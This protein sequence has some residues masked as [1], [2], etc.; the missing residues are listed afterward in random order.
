MQTHTHTERKQPSPRPAAASGIQVAV[1]EV[2]HGDISA[3][4]TLSILGAEESDALRAE[5]LRTQWMRAIRGEAEQ[6]IFGAMMILLTQHLKTVSTRGHGGKF[7]EKGGGVE[8]WLKENA[9]EIKRPTAYRWMKAAQGLLQKT[10]IAGA[11][12]LQSLLGTAEADLP[13][14]Q[15][16]QQMELFSTMGKHSQG[17]LIELAPGHRLGGSRHSQCPKC[18]TNLR[19]SSVAICPKC[20][21]STGQEAEKS[22]TAEEALAV[23]QDETRRAIRDLLESGIAKGGWKLLEDASVRAL[24]DF[25]KYEEEKLALWLRTPKK[26]RETVEL[27]TLV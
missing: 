11:E 25:Y 27:K 21:E 23:R 8:G 14:E 3:P 6:H 15:R 20:G 17:E 1:A 10:G 2:T 18:N 9:P 19:N 4:G 12:E 24:H 22:L 26:H 5:Q 7:G 16:A 13:P